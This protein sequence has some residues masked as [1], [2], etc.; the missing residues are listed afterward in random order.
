MQEA[1]EQLDKDKSYFTERNLEKFTVAIKQFIDQEKKVILADVAFSNG[2]DNELVIMLD[3]QGILHVYTIHTG[4]HH[5]A[6]WSS[7]LGEYLLF[8]ASSWWDIP[9]Q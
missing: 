3:E 2:G 1:S 6:L 4:R 7:A 9:Q 8:Y 5:A